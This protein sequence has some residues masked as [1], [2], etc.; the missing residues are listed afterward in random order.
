[1]R[2][3]L[4]DHSSTPRFSCTSNTRGWILLDHFLLLLPN[5]SLGLC[6]S[7]T[8]RALKQSA[9]KSLISFIAN[10][11]YLL[12]HG[13]VLPAK[14]NANS[15][16]Y[17]RIEQVLCHLFHL[18]MIKKAWESV[19]MYERNSNLLTTFLEENETENRVQVV[20]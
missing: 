4:G 7:T 16:P 20:L 5:Q 8:S 1:M 17:S 15:Q 9:I 11:R 13:L 18:F 6:L 19:C 2:D 14:K 12:Q 3:I 10:T